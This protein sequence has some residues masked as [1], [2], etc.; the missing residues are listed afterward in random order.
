MCLACLTTDVGFVSSS[1]I[2]WDWVGNDGGQRI[3]L[4]IGPNLEICGVSENG[5]RSSSNL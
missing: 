4:E 2:A 5:M 3:F 1:M